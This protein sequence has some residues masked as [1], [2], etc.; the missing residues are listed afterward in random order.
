MS[1]DNNWDWIYNNFIVTK[2]FEKTNID[3]NIDIIDKTSGR[4]PY[5]QDNVNIKEVW[6]LGE[7][8]SFF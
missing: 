7:F 8:T 5:D 3:G 2:I 6:I 4:P 1:I